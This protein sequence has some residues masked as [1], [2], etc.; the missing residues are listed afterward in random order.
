MEKIADVYKDFEEGMD[1]AMQ[2]QYNRTRAWNNLVSGLVTIALTAISAGTAAPGMAMA[3]VAIGLTGFVYESGLSSMGA[4]PLAAKIVGA[5]LTLGL[6]AAAG[7]GGL[8]VRV[9]E[10]AKDTVKDTVKEQVATALLQKEVQK[11]AM[12][13]A[14]LDDD[15]WNEVIQKLSKDYDANGISSFNRKREQ[16]KAQI[17]YIL[18]DICSIYNRVALL[19]PALQAQLQQAVELSSSDYWRRMFREELDKAYFNCPCCQW[20]GEAAISGRCKFTIPPF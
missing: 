16:L 8:L 4:D 1:V 7:S 20:E 14:V 12:S 13:M 5:L 9:G 18:D 11:V 6:G 19:V 15:F 10:S 2:L 3:A 17:G